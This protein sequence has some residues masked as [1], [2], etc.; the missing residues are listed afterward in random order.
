MLELAWPQLQKWA[1]CSTVVFP[2]MFTLRSCHSLQKLRITMSSP[3]SQELLLHLMLWLY[4]INSL[5]MEVAGVSPSE[6]PAYLAPALWMFCLVCCLFQHLP[7][8]SARFL[9][10]ARADHKRWHLNRDLRT[11]WHERWQPKKGPE[12][13][14]SRPKM[15]R[16]SLGHVYIIEKWKIS[17]EQKTKQS[18]R[19]SVKTLETLCIGFKKLC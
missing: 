11:K 19:E 12:W 9:G 1:K 15:R 7:S 5:D 13:G 4:I 18:E 8:L 17:K 14:N 2:K 16:H 10:Q 6:H 3:L